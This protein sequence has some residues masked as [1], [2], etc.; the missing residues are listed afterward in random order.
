MKIQIRTLA[1]AGLLLGFFVVGLGAWTRLADAGLSCPDWP[2]CYGHLTWPTSP[3]EI[4]RADALYA[5][6]APYSVALAIPEMIH[7]I[8]AGALGLLVLGLLILALRHRT[9]LTRRA[10][11]I[12]SVL[13]GL[14][15]AQATFGYLTVSLK[16]WP[17]IVVTHLLGGFSVLA[18]L[19]WLWLETGPAPRS[20]PAGAPRI[21]AWGALIAV[22]LQ[23]ALGG[24]LS[25]NYAALAC[26]ELPGCRQGAFWPPMD[27]ASGFNLFGLD[28]GVNYLGGAL[29]QESRTAIHIVHRLWA[30]VVC[31]LVITWAWQLRSFGWRLLAPGGADA[32]PAAWL[33]LLVGMQFSLGL[34]NIVLQLPLGIAVAHN[35]GAALLLLAG[36]YALH[37]SSTMEASPA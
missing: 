10:L 3:D 11:T 1:A 18:L 2:T 13:A 5:D 19:F 25:A 28:I 16:L 8:V 14:I 15:V 23:I 9:G 17:H 12:T 37:R 31:A 32:S 20:G 34:L 7:R 21:L 22:V 6:D 24:W 27:F 29:S 36:V 26:T 4:A 33:L 30:L 35:L